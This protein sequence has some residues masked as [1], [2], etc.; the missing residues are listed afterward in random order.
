MN[1]FIILQLK[2]LSCLTLILILVQLNKQNII[3]EEISFDL[4]NEG[5][6]IVRSSL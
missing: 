6:M 4:Q 3:L 5:F 1:N 2:E